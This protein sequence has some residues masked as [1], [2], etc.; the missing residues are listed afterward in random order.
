MT[1]SVKFGAHEIVG[2]FL[3]TSYV[4]VRPSSCLLL[5]HLRLR[6]EPLLFTFPSSSIEYC[7]IL[8]RRIVKFGKRDQRKTH[9][10]NMETG[11][12]G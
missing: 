9:D 6:D 7:I 12:L 3:L 2:V 5:T 1:I 11:L 10:E 8:H 4:A